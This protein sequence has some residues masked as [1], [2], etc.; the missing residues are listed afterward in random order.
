MMRL[1]IISITI[2]ISMTNLALPSNAIGNVNWQLLEENELGKEWLDLGSIKKINSNEISV[3]TKY[4]EKPSEIK[5]KGETSLYVMRINCE[6]KTFRDT[7]INGFPN[8][9]SKWRTSNDDE[10]IDIVISKSCSEK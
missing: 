7:S 8:L 10:L 6:E 1:I 2:M 5:E 3:L 4:Y 9:N